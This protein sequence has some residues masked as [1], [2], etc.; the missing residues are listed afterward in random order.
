MSSTRVAVVPLDAHL[1]VIR[2]VINCGC[3]HLRLKHTGADDE[4]HVDDK[5]GQYEIVQVPVVDVVLDLLAQLRR[6]VRVPVPEVR[7]QEIK[8]M[9]T[10]MVYRNMAVGESVV[11]QLGGF[12]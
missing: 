9:M 1:H 11:S 7:Y 6:R 8:L 5:K 3:K 2:T 10:A 4:N 12:H